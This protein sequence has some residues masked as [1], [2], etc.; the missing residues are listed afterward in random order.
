MYM[1]GKLLFIFCG[2]I[3]MLWAQTSGGKIHVLARAY[4]D[5]IC[6]RWA[7]GSYEGWMTGNQ[8]GYRIIRYTL[9]RNGKI[10]PEPDSILLTPDPLLPYPLS[11]WELK[12]GEDKYSAIA[13][14]AL[15]GRITTPTTGI[16]ELRQ[17]AENQEQRYS[18]AMLAADMS[19]AAARA[20][21]LYYT[22]H[23]V[24]KGEKYL[25]RIYTS[26]VKAEWPADTGF[27]F[28]GPDEML[29]LPRPPAPE[30]LCEGGRIILHW[31]TSLLGYVFTCWMAERSAD[32]TGYYQNLTEEPI[33]SI[34]ANERE[35]GTILFPDTLLPENGDLYYRIR[36][37]NAFGEI[38]LPSEPVKAI[39]CGR[40][41]PVPFISSTLA[42]N[43]GQVVL[44][45]M[46]VNHGQKGHPVSNEIK[47]WR[48][49]VEGKNYT[50][51]GEVSSSDTSFTDEVPAET[52]YYKLSVRTASG[53]TRFSFPVLVQLTDTI[54]PS[55]P[56]GILGSMDTSGIVILRWKKNP[57]PDLYGYRIYRGNSKQEEFSQITIAPVTDTVFYDSIALNNLTKKIYY[58]LMAIDKRQNYSTLSEIIEVAKTDRI[59]PPSPALYAVTGEERGIVLSFL[60]RTADD[61][62]E[63]QIYRTCGNDSCLRMITVLQA[64]TD[65]VVWTDTSA[66]P[67]VLYSYR[68]QLADSSGNL[69][70]PSEEITM[71]RSFGKITS[72]K[73]TIKGKKGAGKRSVELFWNNIHPDTRKIIIYRAEE[74]ETFRSY[75]SMAGNTKRFT[76]NQVLAGKKYRYVIQPVSNNGKHL[77]PSDP[78]DITL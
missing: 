75:A 5:S 66:I 74:G 35:T 22:D 49:S 51:I 9:I 12:A 56:S 8:Y 77:P 72:A 71:A 27:I 69:S 13:A 52:N 43:D 17:K 33:A 16:K 29:P 59:P 68:I 38:S 46:N 53:E 4:K 25:Y 55:S 20:L 50:C 18:L 44:S 47:I 78:L 76:D 60:G 73:P 54:P 28:T 3:N 1:K 40:D 45:W 61:I 34:S 57:E 64:P 7:P 37:I 10:L 63:A 26:S 23:T 2:F 48:S 58:R 65:T 67:G 62:K 70:P 21:A 30:I 24:Q 41:L 15:Y 11:E 42:T 39:P 36:G 19:P 6:L 31:N 32:S 14:Q